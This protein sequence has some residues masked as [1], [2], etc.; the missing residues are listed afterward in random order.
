MHADHVLDNPV[1]HALNS[2]QA[3]FAIGTDLAK[4]YPFDVSIAAGFAEHSEQAFF[5][6]AQTVDAGK[7][8][9]LFEAE[10]LQNIPH[11]TIERSLAIDQMV[12]QKPV[13]ATE[14]SDDVVELS[15]DDVPEM[16]QLVKLTQPGPFFK[17]TIEMG[18]YFGIR[19]NGALVAMAGQRVH[20]T[21]YCEVSA[22][23]TH[24]D[25]R[26]KGYARRLNSILVNAIW[27]EGKVPFLHVVPDNTSAYRVYES[28]NFVK[29][30]EI[31][32][33]VI[34]HA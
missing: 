10:P 1:W 34:S 24:P 14:N 33:Q 18:R 11:W 19:Q 29:R 32:V 28:L 16:W 23:C 27:E 5:D 30:R 15:A 22:V 6:L 4:R 13:S 17:R 2:D 25:W 31:T 3:H 26:G 12:C 20:L 9:A 8:I 7:K 21:G